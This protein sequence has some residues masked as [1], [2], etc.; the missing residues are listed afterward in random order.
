MRRRRRK[1][2]LGTQ[3]LAFWLRV[4]AEAKWG[5]F[6]KLFPFSIVKELL[7]FLWGELENLQYSAVIEAIPSSI[8]APKAPKNFLVYQNFSSFI[9]SQKRVKMRENFEKSQKR[10]KNLVESLGFKKS[11]IFRIWLQKSQSGNPGFV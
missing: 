10:V 1:I 11:Q 4:K 5:K 9:K 7:Q 6:A 2:F 8:I 3:I